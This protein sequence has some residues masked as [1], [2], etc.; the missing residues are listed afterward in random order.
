MTD[1]ADRWGIHPAQSWL[2]GE[3][4][5]RPVEFDEKSGMWN[6]YGHEEAC[7]VLADAKTYSSAHV[8]D[9]FP[10]QADRSLREGNLLDLDPPD[11][12]KLRNLVSKAFSGKVVADLEPRVTA[13]THELLDQV[14]PDGFELVSAL[15]YPLPVIVIAELLGLPASDRE[16]FREWVDKLF[17]QNNEFSLNDSPEKMAE[18]FAEVSAGLLPLQD[19]LREHITARRRSPGDDLI[20]GL[21]QAEVDGQRLNDNEVVNFSMVLLVAGHITTTMLLGNTT[22]CLDAH[23]AQR[24]RVRA[25]RSLVP[26]AIEESLRFFTP[27]AALARATTTPVTLGGQDIPADQLL[28]VWLGAANRDG[29]R[30]ADPHLFD[31]GRDPNPHLGFGRGIHFCVGAPLARLEGRVAV[32]ALLDRFPGLH[33]DPDQAPTFMPSP[34]MTGVKTLPLRV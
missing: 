21:V 33:V 30:F 1:L 16:L 4:P 8:Q 20:S 18:D 32:N 29:R 7:Q 11:H 3:D 26:V 15:A 24:E 2:R 5:A 9:L 6:V 23:P 10:V 17:A 31:A 34:A 25:D 13:L 28:M 19:Y 12:R 22:L 27:F 14:D